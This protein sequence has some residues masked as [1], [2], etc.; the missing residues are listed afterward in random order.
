MV[1]IKS[2]IVTV[3]LSPLELAIYSSEKTCEA[4]SIM[5][6]QW[7]E[8]NEERKQ[9]F[10]DYYRGLIKETKEEIFELNT[11]HQFYSKKIEKRQQEDPDDTFGL[12]AAKSFMT[13]YPKT[14]ESL[15][16]KLAGYKQKKKMFKNLEEFDD[17]N[18]EGHTSK[19]KAIVKYLKDLF[20]REPS[21]R[22]IVFSKYNDLLELLGQELTE[23]DILTSNLK[24]NIYRK[25]KGLNNFKASKSAVKVMLMSFNKT[26]SGTN[27]IEAS[28]VIFADPL[29]RSATEAKAIEAQAIGRAQR[30]GQT[31][32]V[33]VVRF[34][35]ADS[36]EMKLHARNTKPEKK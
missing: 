34:L 5:K 13:S 29:D 17:E 23:G 9:H 28:H 25:T 35:V 32:E 19:L 26:A 4:C 27:L 12:G 31:Q 1:A 14:K 30:Q 8:T 21:K 33:T 36:I 16:T 18:A 24:G 10:L 15:T 11:K 2:E 3:N 6:S 20:E 7:G 22:V